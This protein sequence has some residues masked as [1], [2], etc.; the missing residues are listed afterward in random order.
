M[1]RNL[2]NIINPLKTVQMLIKNIN[3]QSKIKKKKEKPLI[4]LQNYC[5]GSLE[6]PKITSVDTNEDNQRVNH[7]CLINLGP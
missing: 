5:L 6:T 3:K 1:Y 7:Q 2:N 4:L